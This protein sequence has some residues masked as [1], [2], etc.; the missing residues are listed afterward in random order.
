[1]GNACSA[2]DNPKEG[3]EGGEAMVRLPPV[4]PFDR[5]SGPGVWKGDED[6][7]VSLA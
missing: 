5:E 6:T 7:A 1:M 2:E 3:L 4:L